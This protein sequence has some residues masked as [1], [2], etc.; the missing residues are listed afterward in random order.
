MRHPCSDN[1]AAQ[2]MFASPS[3][4]KHVRT[5]SCANDLAR[6]SYTRGLTSFFTAGAS[7]LHPRQ[8]GPAPATDGAAVLRPVLGALDAFE[9][10]VG[11]FPARAGRGI[12]GR[13]RAHAGA[14]QEHDGLVFWHG[15][16][17]LAEK[18]RVLT[19]AGVGLPFDGQR[20]GYLA[21][22]EQLWFRPDIHE[23]RAGL[24]QGMGLR[25][26]QRT[27]VLESHLAAALASQ[28]LNFLDVVHCR[29]IIV[30]RPNAQP[31]GLE[32]EAAPI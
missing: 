15:S 20:A 22:V 7:A 13:M 1:R 25:R 16:G 29:R 17:K 18:F 10:V 12:R 19:A 28:L 8:A 32:C 4:A 24:H 27:R 21:D 26:G 31:L 3:S 14:A 2:F 30:V 23:L 6:M 5:P 9:N 11:L